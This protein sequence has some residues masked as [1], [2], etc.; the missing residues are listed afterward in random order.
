MRKG[1]QARSALERAVE[2]NP[3]S[4]LACWAL[5]NQLVN[6]GELEPAQALFERS[7]RLSPH[8]AYL[9]HFEGALAGVHFQQARDEE[10][11]VHAQRSVD[12]Q[13]NE[14]STYRPLKAAA[15][16][17][18]GRLDEARTEVA[19]LRAANPD[20]NLALERSIASS[21]L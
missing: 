20:W 18:A 9:H 10:A 14:R 4:A 21:A 8:D 6:A 15:L 16:G 7:I 19:E 2:L 5:G 13:P 17:H 1:D 12:V 3:S 11:L